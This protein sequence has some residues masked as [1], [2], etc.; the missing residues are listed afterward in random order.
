MASSDRKPVV[1]LKNEL[2]EKPK[3]FSFFQAMRLLRFFLGKEEESEDN[4]DLLQKHVRIRPKLALSHPG[5]DIDEIEVRDSDQPKYKMT[6]N[7][8]GLYG[9]SSPLPTFYTEDLLDDDAEDK[10]SAR[11]LIDII[12]HP[13][14]TLLNQS[15]TKYRMPIKL[16]DEKD[17]KYKEILFS[18]LGIGVKEIR[19]GLPEADE[20]LRY[21]GLLTQQPKSAKGLERLIKDVLGVDHVEIDQCVERVVKIPAEQHFIL[22]KSG[23]VLGKECYLGESIKDRMK[24]FRIKLGPVDADKYIK[25]LPGQAEHEKIIF[26]VNLYLFEPLESDLEI[27]L[28]GKEVKTARLSNQRWARLGM[29]TWIFSGDYDKPISSVFNLT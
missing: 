24:K 1:N 11:D 3:T 18:L 26:Y 23:N 13:L 16:I 25:L 21:T 15:Y 27:F 19:D 20:L 6:V 29:D 8:L 5:T 12:N 2:L 9:E 17:Q 14:Y 7:F 4:G 10:T 28:D 22:G